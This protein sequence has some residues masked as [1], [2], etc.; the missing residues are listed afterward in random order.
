MAGHS[1]CLET[2]RSSNPGCQV[3]RPRAPP[4][5]THTVHQASGLW[6]PLSLCP[7]P[8]RVLPSLWVLGRL[9]WEPHHPVTGPGLLDPSAMGRM[10]SSQSLHLIGFGGTGVQPS[11]G[12]CESQV[13]RTPPIDT[14][15]TRHQVMVRT[16]RTDRASEGLGA[17]G[18][19]SRD[20]STP[21]GGNSTCKGP[22]AGPCL[23]FGR[24][25]E[26]ARVAGAERARGSGMRARG[27]RAA[28]QCLCCVCK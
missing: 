2:S 12:T 25:S 15:I 24:N 3:G 26:G 10:F 14:Q 17:A 16:T 13:G 4:P 9:V 22:G 21:G 5:H 8:V 6:W 18:H 7:E 19:V 11:W 28:V 27:M 20:L 1:A 23:A